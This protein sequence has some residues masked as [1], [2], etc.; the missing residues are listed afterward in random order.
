MTRS[1]HPILSAALVF[2]ACTTQ[3]AEPPALTAP[4]ILQKVSAAYGHIASIRIVA[5]REESVVRRG[6]T[7]SG[8]ADFELTMEGRHRFAVRL[9]DVN[10]RDA[11]AVSDGENTWRALPSKKQWTHM[12]AASSVGSDDDSNGPEEPRHDLL[13]VVSSTLL[14]QY[15]ALA[16]FAENPE[17]VRSEDVKVN[18]VKI[19]CYVIH[20]RARNADYDLWID[21]QRFLVLQDRERMQSSGSLVEM[22]V[23]LSALEVN[24][25][26]GDAPFH[27][28]PGKGWTEEEMLVLPGEERMLLAG[29]RAA[30]FSLKTLEGDSLALDQTR[31]KVVVLDFW[32]TWCPPCRAE[33]PSIEKLSKEFAGS[34]RFY[35]INDEEAGTVKKFVAGNHYEFPVLMDSKRL[36]HR[37]YGVSAIPTLLILDKDGVIR[38]HFIGSRSEASLRKAVQS[39]LARN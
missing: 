1:P 33:L 10:G 29:E 35:G 5:K 38:E 16:K 15:A 34:V 2:L 20:C 17:L 6:Q 14:L 32:A 37:M 30:N 22:K 27:F 21:K 36:V 7:G 25:Q 12:A 4:D 18:G 11:I 39:V 23:K 19:P 31:G 28:Q 3:A 8:T 13:A 26:L 24:P 9:N